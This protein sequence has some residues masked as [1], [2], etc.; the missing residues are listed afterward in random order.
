MSLHGTF[1]PYGLRPRRVGLWGLIGRREA[2]GGS[3]E[4]DPEPTFSWSQ[5]MRPDTGRASASAIPEVRRAWPARP[6]P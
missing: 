6:H 4:P 5:L 2:V 1:A 3:V